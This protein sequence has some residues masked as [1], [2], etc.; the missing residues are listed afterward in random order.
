MRI[1]AI[2]CILTALALSTL[3]ATDY[4]ASPTG[5]SGNTGLSTNSPW[6]LDTAL[7]NLGPGITVYLMDGAYDTPVTIEN[8]SG[9]TNSW[10]TLKAINKWQALFTNSTSHGITVENTAKYIVLDGLCV[11]NSVIDGFKLHHD[12]TVRNCRSIKNQECGIN[13]SSSD[14]SNI[15]VDKCLVEYSGFGN[16]AAGNFHGIYGSGRDCVVMSSVS[17]YNDGYGIHFYTDYTNVWN[18]NIKVYNNLC[19]GHTNKRDLTI[20]SAV[21]GTGGLPGTNY[22]FGNTLLQ[23]ATFAYG[24]VDVTNNIIHPWIIEPTVP[25]ESHGTKVP[26][27]H[28]DYNMSTVTITPSGS[29]DVITNAITYINTNNALFWITSTNAG[30]AKALSSIYGTNDFFGNSQSS[31]SD[32]GFVQYSAALAADTRNLATTNFPDY[33]EQL[34]VTNPIAKTLTMQGS[35]RMRG[36]IDL[37]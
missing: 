31:V 29:H 2:T 23:G 10:A 9:T 16:E 36:R 3:D 26:T 17:R 27:V 12:I 19:Y 7:T 25:I 22:V 6:D 20:W 34:T 4:Y 28:C 1:L 8:V 24:H 18:N 5:S 11:S 33:W 13:F 30:R 14:S 35:V 32:I 15:V 37:K 21:D